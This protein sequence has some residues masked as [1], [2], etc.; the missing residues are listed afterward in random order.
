MLFRRTFIPCFLLASIIAALVP[1][2]TVLAD[3][4]KDVL[5]LIPDDA[6]GFLVLKSLGAVDDRAVLIKETLGLQFPTP[7]TPLALAPLN[8]ADKIDM[9][10]PLGVVLMDA[11]KYGGGMNPG[12]AM[13]L[14]V[15]AKDAQ[16]L[17]DGFAAKEDQEA[18]GEEAGAA[19]EK[20][21]AGEG[22]APGKKQPE[23]KKPPKAGK[24]GAGLELHQP[25]EK[26]P[27]KEKAGDEG[28][29]EGVS[30]IK[31]MGQPVYAAVKGKY[32]IVGPN[33]ECIV[34]V[35]KT[36]KT[37]AEGMAEARLAALEKSDLYL[38]LSMSAVVSAT[39]DMIKPLLLMAT[40]A[41]DPQ[42]K[43]IEKLF[44]IFEE[45]AA[46]D[47]GMRFDKS[48]LTLVALM[49]P[50]KDS[51]LE[52]LMGD[53]KNTDKPL[54]AMLP[55]EKYLF[56]MGT[57]GGYSEHSTK[58]SE[59]DWFSQMLKPANVKGLN[60]AALK[61]IDAELMKM[62]KAAGPMA[63][64]VSFIPEGAEGMFGVTVIAQPKAPQEYVDGIRKIYKTLLTVADG[65]T[66]EKAADKT[67]GGKDKKAADKKE[68]KGEEGDE[69][70]DAEGKGGKNSAK[71]LVDKLKQYIVH[72]ADAETVE[73]AK[74]DTLAVK[75]QVLTELGQFQEDDVGLI[76]KVLGKEIAIRFAA[77]G[78]KHFVMTFGGGKKRFESVC[79]HLKS[80]GDSL[81]KDAGIKEAATQLPSPRISEFYFAA[82]NIVQAIKAVAKALGEEEEFPFDVPA[83]NAP[84]AMSGAL[85]GTAQQINIVIPMKLIKATK[86]AI[87]KQAGAGAGDFDEDEGEQGQKPAAG[88]AKDAAAA[89][90]KGKAKTEK[91][92]EKDEDDDE[93]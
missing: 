42:G 34:N 80:A 59:E 6:W 92:K 67:E 38:S 74:V 50:Q 26:K 61:T 45:L 30:K 73:G 82:D 51:D 72:T 48:G 88:K 13:V 86:D 57:T 2:S 46:F 91:K 40:A 83:I 55:S 58:F 21:G 53:S 60:E 52:K 75:L 7:V 43:N 65:E 17:L 14:L 9:T 44:K 31:I 39:K 79:K 35:L 84:V 90:D 23:Q 37:L 78:D 41:S 22:K 19:G 89:K 18:G 47:L 16:A 71:E 3:G 24:P 69:D 64:S 77:V 10:R 5:Q 76:E 29:I 87:D 1:A 49:T 25:A 93:E 28:A 15:P 11:R 4:P 32:L 33:Q 12:E 8:V 63:M 54:L 62:A 70:K 20:K 27:G 68:A 66:K 36:K 56:T 81:D 85:I